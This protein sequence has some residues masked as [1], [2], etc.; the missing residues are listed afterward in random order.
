[1]NT[2]L[3]TLQLDRNAMIAMQMLAS[4]DASRYILTGVHFEVLDE[5][6]VLVGTNGMMLGALNT[7]ACPQGTLKE[8]TADLTCVKLLKASKLPVTVEVFES[9]VSFK[10][11]G[12]KIV[13]NRIEG[14][15]PHWRTVVPKSKFCHGSYSFNPNLVSKLCRLSS[16][17]APNQGG[18][19]SMIPHA[20][21]KNEFSPLSPYS[22]LIPSCESFYGVLMPMRATEQTVPKWAT[23]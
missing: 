21:D 20:D 3:L 22:V 12:I 13:T 9:E 16:L 10:L 2:P 5:S 6:V 19:V 14:D 17:L 15:F 11:N 8:F 4:S 7:K 18:S 1:M 23:T